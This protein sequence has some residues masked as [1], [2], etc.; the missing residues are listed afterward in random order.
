MP[1]S[2]PNTD[3]TDEYYLEAACLIVEVTSDSTL[4]KDYLEKALAYQSIPTLQ[5]YLIVA[6]DKAQVDILVRDGDAWQLQQFDDSSAADIVLPCLN[7][8]L[9]LTE[10]YAGMNLVEENTQ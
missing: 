10:I 4:R 5:A 6:Q 2:Q 3:D 9:K 8:S 1:D 7:T